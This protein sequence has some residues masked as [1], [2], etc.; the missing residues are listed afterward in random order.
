VKKLP[1]TILL[2]LSLSAIVCAQALTPPEFPGGKQEFSSFLN[3]NLKW[4]SDSM[5]DTQGVVIVGF[6]VEKDGSLTNIHITKGMRPVFN[7]EALRVI[8]LSPKWIPASRGKKRV[9]SQYTVPISFTL[10]SSTDTIEAKG[11][12]REPEFPGGIEKFH[13]YIRSN[14]RW[15]V[16]TVQKE[17]KVIISFVIE[18]DGRLTNIKI[19]RGLSPD[20][21]KEALRLVTNS[22]RWKP[23]IQNG[24]AVRVGYIVPVLFKPNN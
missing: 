18:P 17:G 22:G 1:L 24:K 16:N 15:P 11:K 13:E 2:L 10:S 12:S 23:G 6:F 7:N 20:I 14:A 5:D 8:K 21:D 3:K 4:P 19:G 9:K